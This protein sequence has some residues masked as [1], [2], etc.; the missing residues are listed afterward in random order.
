MSTVEVLLRLA[1]AT[2]V[3]SC[4]S[5]SSQEPSSTVAPNRILISG[6]DRT[7]AS[8]FAATLD[9]YFHSAPTYEFAIQGTS[10][11]ELWSSVA[12]LTAAQAGQGSA[13]MQVST[14]P[15]ATGVAYA[16]RHMADGSKIDAS[17]GSLQISF[18]AGQITGS[19]STTPF[20]VGATFR[21]DVNV[22][23]WVPSSA[24]DLQSGGGSHGGSAEPLVNDSAFA[25]AQCAPFKSL[26]GH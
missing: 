23:C 20:A 15:W 17:D 3:C 14:S 11:G 4:A 6:I 26:V 13:T 9:L 10:G 5:A 22:A 8:P 18:S 2:L 19:A 12:S 7:Y 25:S 16:T 21:G 1:S 24:L